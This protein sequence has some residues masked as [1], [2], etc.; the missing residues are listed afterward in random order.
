MCTFFRKKKKNSRPETLEKSWPK[1][2]VNEIKSCSRFFFEF[3]PFSGCEIKIFMGK[4]FKKLSVIYLILAKFFIVKL[5]KLQFTILKYFVKYDF[6]ESQLDMHIVCNI[7]QQHVLLF[8][9][10]IIMA[11]IS[12]RKYYNFFEQIIKNAILILIL[13]F[14]KLHE[15]GKH[16]YEL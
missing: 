16:K 3:F 14:F 11:E 2:S 13:L 7:V 12:S 8:F 6:F 5:H 1:I 15:M 4:Y 10:N 9:L